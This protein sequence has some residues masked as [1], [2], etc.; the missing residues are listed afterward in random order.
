MKDELSASAQRAIAELGLAPHPEGGW[1]R[2]TWASAH[3]AGGGTLD[4]AHAG[5][6]GTGDVRPLASL[7][8]FLLPKG[9]ASAWHKV[10]ADEI[11]LWHGPASLALELGGM[12]PEPDG[13]H[14]ERHVLGITDAGLETQLVIP[15]GTWQRTLPAEGDILLSCVVSPG[16]VYAGFELANEPSEA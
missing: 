3:A 11:W 9:D 12:G 1:Y 13:E 15:A 14:A 16:F 6:N 7:I 2:R 5:E 10:D 4:E 8:Y